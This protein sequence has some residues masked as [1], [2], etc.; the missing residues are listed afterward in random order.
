[1]NGMANKKS[2]DVMVRGVIIEAIPPTTSIFAMFEPT[3]SP[4]KMF[5]RCFL[6]DVIV[7]ASSGTDVPNAIKLIA[8][9]SSLMLRAWAIS[10]A[11]LTRYF[12]LR[13]MANIDKIETP[14]NLKISEKRFALNIFFISIPFLCYCR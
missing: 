9:I 10:A 1:M 6:A 3:R 4:I 14:N 11:E 7:I 13:I 2:K 12:A 8:I 5:G